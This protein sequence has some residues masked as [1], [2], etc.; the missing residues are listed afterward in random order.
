[1]SVLPREQTHPLFGTLVALLN[2]TDYSNL[3]P[4]QSKN[5]LIWNVEIVGAYPDY[6]VIT[7]NNQTVHDFMLVYASMELMEWLTDIC[8]EI[9]NQQS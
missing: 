3:P 5:G 2:K 6:L 8:N 7:K 1:M 9:K 4:M